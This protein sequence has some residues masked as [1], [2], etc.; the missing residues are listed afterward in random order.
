MGILCLWF[1]DVVGN[2]GQ[3]LPNQRMWNSES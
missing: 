1:G 3:G 2:W